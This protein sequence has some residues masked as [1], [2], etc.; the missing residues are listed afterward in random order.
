MAALAIAALVLAIDVKRN[1]LAPFPVAQTTHFELNS[2]TSLRAL[3][4]KLREQGLIA[5]PIYL[6][7]YAR[8]RGIS[9][10]LQAGEYSIEPGMSVL[11]LL[12]KMQSGEVRLYSFTVIEGWTFGQLLD[13]MARNG[14]LR[15]TIE[16]NAGAVR[17][18]MQALGQP[19]S[20]PEGQ[21]L[22]DTYLF[23]RGTTDIEFLRRANAALQKR[24]QS[25]WEGRASDLPLRTPYEALILASIIEKET[26]VAD[27]RSLIAAVFINRLNK[28]MRLQTDPTVIYG[29]GEA[30]D[31][32]IRFR[33][34]RQDTPYNTYTRAGLPPTPIAL[35]GADS[36]HAALHPAAS[37]ALYFVSKGDGSHVFSD[38]LLEHEA[39][40][41]LYQRR[42]RNRSR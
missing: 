41:D 8:L 4:V 32:N 27:E 28:R 38:N 24:L 35:P 30:F 39:A 1:L 6:V 26:A 12:R 21:F 22:P 25:E 16:R 20:H 18:V 33:D 19:D 42:G 14:N 9:T 15:Q 36:I 40:V 29:M 7:V 5:R 13:A 23:A 37:P 10:R 11:D 34:L 3:A 17:T 31:G 2:G